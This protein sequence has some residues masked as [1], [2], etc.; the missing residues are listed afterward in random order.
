MRVGMIGLGRTG[1]DMVGRLV[2][3]GHRRVVHHAAAAAVQALA[4]D[5]VR[6]ARALVAGLVPPRTVWV[7]AAAAVVVP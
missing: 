4:G 3:A 5:G 2:R 1:A 6:V 7:M